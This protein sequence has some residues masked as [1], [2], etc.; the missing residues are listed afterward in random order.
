MSIQELKAKI[1]SEVRSSDIVYDILAETGLEKLPKP[2]TEMHRIFYSLTKEEPELLSFLVFNTSGVN[3]HSRELDEILFSLE[4][5]SIITAINP[6]FEYSTFNKVTGFEL[7]D[8]EAFM[9]EAKKKIRHCASYV[10]SQVEP[11]GL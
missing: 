8:W 5:S 9:P 2:R 1:A 10:R 6:A 4:A 3:P 7:K 11:L